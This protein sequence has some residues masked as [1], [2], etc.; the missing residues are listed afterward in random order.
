EVLECPVARVDLGVRSDVVAVVAQRRRVERQEPDR[1]DTEL[2]Q[3]IELRSQ[4]AEITD[5]VAVGVRER[6]DVQLVD[7]GVL[8]PQR[9]RGDGACTFFFAYGHAL[10]S[11]HAKYSKSV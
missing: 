5:P 8:E 6:A 11:A 1:G 3:V 10:F 9:V 4:A 7:D 2:L